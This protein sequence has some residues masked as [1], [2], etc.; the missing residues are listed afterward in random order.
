MQFERGFFAESWRLA[1]KYPIVVVGVMVGEYLIQAVNEFVSVGAG[2]TIASVFLWSWLAY[3]MHSDMLLSPDRD[4]SRDTSVYGFAGRS[5]GLLMLALLPPL[6]LVLGLVFPGSER[7]ADED[8]LLIIGIMIPA[9]ALTSLLVFTFLGTILPA[10]V[11]NEGR[12]LGMVIARGWR[13]F[14]WI[15]GRLTIGPGLLFVISL[16]IFTVPTLVFDLSGDYLS[17]G[18]PD[19]L[20]TFAAMITY[21]I[22]AWATI[23]V[24]VILSRAFVRDGS[25]NAEIFA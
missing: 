6:F 7:G 20:T 3:M 16:A 4:K 14:F 11:A 9:F 1:R 8:L 21:A 24:A 13:Q 5:F 17:G 18:V 2:A 12:G 22:Q 15:A 10:H 23:M 19:P 25:T